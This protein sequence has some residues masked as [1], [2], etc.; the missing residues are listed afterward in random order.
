MTDEIILRDQTI[1]LDTC[2]LQYLDDNSLR[3]DVFELLNK[4]ITNNNILAISDYSVFE[5]L[6]G[7]NVSKQESL[8]R[9]VTF[10]EICD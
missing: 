5:L 3:D 8:S 4:L 10:Y 1:I 6:R 2:I 9:I 7:A